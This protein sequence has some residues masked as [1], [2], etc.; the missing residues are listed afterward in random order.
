MF[1][2]IVQIIAFHIFKIK[3]EGEF[4]KDK[5]FVIAV[6]PHTSNW[7]FIIAIGIRRYLKEPIHF[8]GKKELFNPLTAWFFKGLGGTPL[9]RKKNENTVEAMTRLYQEKDVFRMAIA[10]EG[11]RKKVS[12]WKTGFYHI[13]KNAEVP[14]LPVIF[15]W[16]KS[17]M[18]FH[19]LFTPTDD[20]D[21][22]IAYLKSLGKGAT[23]KVPKYT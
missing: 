15:D 7:D 16:G 13:A 14:I 1:S 22:D 17:K 20:I 12:H 11:T 3:L 4:P 10:P 19:P 2:F 23:G 6:Y 9:N 8:V 5:K 18:V 21:T